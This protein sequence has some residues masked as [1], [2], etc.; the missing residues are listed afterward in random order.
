MAPPISSRDLAFFHFLADNDIM[1]NRDEIL[2]LRDE[3]FAE[4]LTR[5]DPFI[6]S[7]DLLSYPPDFCIFTHNYEP[8]YHLYQPTR[9]F[10]STPS[11][12]PGV[13]SHSNNVV[14][15]IIV[16]YGN[17]DVIVPYSSDLASS[18]F[19]WKSHLQLAR[20]AEYS[21]TKSSDSCMPSRLVREEESVEI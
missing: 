14:I 21:G 13:A 12:V 7:I 2:R 20:P 6:I 4:N 18:L 1:E 11:A 3:A 8:E 17:E 9:Q 19:A 10:N 15:H 5:Q 16:P